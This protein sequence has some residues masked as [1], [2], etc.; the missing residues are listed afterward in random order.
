MLD[1]ELNINGTKLSSK[2]YITI[3]P[4]TTVYYEDS[5]SDFVIFD[6]SGCTWTVDG[7]T[8]AKSQHADRVGDVGSYVYGYDDAYAAMSKFSLGSA[9][10]VT[11]SGSNS[12]TAAFSFY[13]TGFDIISATTNTSGTVV[14]SVKSADGSFSKNYLVDTYY[15]YSYDETNGWVPVPDTEAA[16]WQIPVIKVEKLPYGAYNVTLTVAYADIFSHGQ[17]GGESYDFWFDAVRI[18]DPAGAVAGE[19]GSSQTIYDNAYKQD[20]EGWPTYTELRDMMIDA[21]SF[22]ADEEAVS[23]MIFIDGQSGEVS[24][25]DYASYGPKNELYLA[26]SQAVAFILGAED[27]ARRYSDR[28]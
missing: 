16:L 3:V 6:G 7:T 4:A 13:G 26:P 15:G 23:G 5:V 9:H 14:V 19:A 28:T 25:A 1:V 18:Y 8:E 27:N 24:M 12:A 17:N 21:D 22:T 2:K 20:E 10:K 11:V